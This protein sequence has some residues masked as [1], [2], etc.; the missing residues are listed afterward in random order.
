MATF[1]SSTPFANY[2][3]LIITNF[4]ST[5][6]PIPVIPAS[7]KPIEGG[8]IALTLI[9]S[10]LSI[11][12]AI[13]IF[14]AYCVTDSFRPENETRRLLIYLTV[15]DLLVAFG[16]FGGTIRYKAVFGDKEFSLNCTMDT[17]CD[18]FCVVQSFVCA[19]ASMWS[20][21]WNTAIAIHICVALV[22]CRHGSWPWKMKIFTHSV[23]WLVP[24]RYC[25]YMSTKKIRYTVQN[26]I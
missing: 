26:F 4:T 8:D 11:F 15:S 14:V 18:L 5:V 13:L 9:A 17:Q 19:T 16:N 20:F 25:L 12:G 7:Y 10:T 24:C 3:T 1:T 23:C 2:T 22:Y 21:F 6:G